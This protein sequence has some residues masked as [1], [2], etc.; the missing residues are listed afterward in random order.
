MPTY[1]FSCPNQHDT[2]MVS[3]MSSR[4]SSIDCPDCSEI[5]T[6]RPNWAPAPRPHRFGT[7]KWI[8][9]KSERTDRLYHYSCELE[10]DTDEWFENPPDEIECQQKG[11]SL[12]AKKSIGANIETFW[13]QMEREGGYYDQSLGMQIH[14]EAQRKAEAKKRGLTIV[15]GDF[16]V[17]AATYGTSGWVSRLPRPG[18]QRPSLC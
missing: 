10:H 2:E 17:A 9:I 15:D 16:D 14:T 11:C 12:V 3:S 8:H 4:P 6:Q 5:A 13:L 7:N 1:K 18:S